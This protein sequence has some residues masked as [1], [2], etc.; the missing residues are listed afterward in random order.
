VRL[1]NSHTRHTCICIFGLLIKRQ[2]VKHGQQGEEKR[3]VQVNRPWDAGGYVRSTSGLSVLIV[4]FLACHCLSLSTSLHTLLPL[5]IFPPPTGT[6]PRM[7]SCT[8]K[9]YTYCGGNWTEASLFYYCSSWSGQPRLLTAALEQS[10]KKINSRWFWARTVLE[11][12]GRPLQ[13]CRRSTTVMMIVI[14][15]SS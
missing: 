6:A 2:V 14:V 9:S 11:L 13:P 8:R 12:L 7:H 10:K 1:Q 5:P 3:G 4:N 15:V